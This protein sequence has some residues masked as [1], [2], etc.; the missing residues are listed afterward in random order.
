MPLARYKITEGSRRKRIYCYLV[1][2]GCRQ[3]MLIAH[4]PKS[5]S[6]KALT[7]DR[8]NALLAAYQRDGYVLDERQATQVL[9][10]CQLA[11][12]LLDE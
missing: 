5:V 12:I 10:A 2:Y 7:D 11:E 9:D 3:R 6:H 8:L 4:A 1:T